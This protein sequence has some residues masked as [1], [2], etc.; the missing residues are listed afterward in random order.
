MIND[1]WHCSLRGLALTERDYSAG[2]K[3]AKPFRSPNT[4]SSTGCHL[5][6]TPR[7]DYL[8]WCGPV[9]PCRARA[10]EGGGANFLSGE[11]WQ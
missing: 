11:Q 8:L 3:A 1:Q 2:L 4:R 7:A 10:L 6:Q 9:E 5:G